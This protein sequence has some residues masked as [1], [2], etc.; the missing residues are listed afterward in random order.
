ML[1]LWQNRVEH[2]LMF[3]IVFFCGTCG[4]NCTVF[5]FCEQA[6]CSCDEGNHRV[7][8]G[9]KMRSAELLDDDNTMSHEGFI[10]ESVANGQCRSRF[11]RRSGCVLQSCSSGVTFVPA[12]VEN[13][14]GASRAL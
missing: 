1:H 14:G 7:L 8:N 11:G 9:L 12:F 3:T 6:L 5:G 13:D 10:V 2:L 4:T